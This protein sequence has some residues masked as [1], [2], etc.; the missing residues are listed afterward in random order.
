MNLAE[1]TAELSKKSAEKGEVL[2]EIQKL[3][4]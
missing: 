1:A 3:E 2:E 4:V